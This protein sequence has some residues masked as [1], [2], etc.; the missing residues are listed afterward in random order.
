[1]N[2]TSPYSR[3]KEV[4][5]DETVWMRVLGMV[6]SGGTPRCSTLI[7]NTNTRSFYSLLFLSYSSFLRPRTS[8]RTVL[9]KA[10]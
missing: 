2:E 3:P 6:T 1:M 4:M 7:S 8:T 5:K 9:R 10:T